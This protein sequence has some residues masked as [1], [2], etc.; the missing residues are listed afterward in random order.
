MKLKTIALLLVVSMPAASQDAEEK[1]KQLMYKTDSKK[2]DTLMARLNPEDE[3][4][5]LQWLNDRQDQLVRE[6]AMRK[7]EI[8][9]LET[10]KEIFYEREEARRKARK[11]IREES[12]K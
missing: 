10:A 4:Q 12:L 7:E 3:K 5:V 2:F 11:K 1:F 8:K 6:I 9:Y